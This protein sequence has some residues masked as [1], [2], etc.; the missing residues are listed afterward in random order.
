[1]KK[2]DLLK[3]ELVPSHEILSEE[4]LK[5]LLK[6]YSIKKERLSRILINDPIVEAIGA[7]DGDV[8]KIIRKKSETAGTSVSYRLVSKAVL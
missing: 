4:E 6:I 7:K 1:M 8:I 2:E 3:H 5:T